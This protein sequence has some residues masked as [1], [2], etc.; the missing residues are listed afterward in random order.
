MLKLP[1]YTASTLNSCVIGVPHR[2]RP[3]FR[4]WPKNV[5][6]ALEY[7]EIT[8]P[9]VLEKSTREYPERAAI[10]F[11]DTTLTYE[12]LYENVKRFASALQDLGVRKGDRVAVYLPNCPQFIVTTYGA[13]E[14]GAVVVPCSTA[15]K[16]MEL[17]RQL[18][19]SGARILITHERLLQI[20]SETVK[21]T[22]IEHLIVTSEQDYRYLEDVNNAPKSEGDKYIPLLKLLQEYEPTPTPV[23]INPRE[24]LAFL[25]YTGGTTGTPKG[26]M[27]THFN[28]VVDQLHE[29]FFYQLKRGEEV[30]LLFLPLF[31]IYGLNRCMGT[32]L[33]AAATI[34]LLERF[35][36]IKV[37]EAIQRYKVTV[38]P[39]VPTVYNALISYS[40]IKKYDL[41]S[42]RIWKSAAAPLPT[43]TWLK[44]RDLVGASIVIGWGLTEAS[45]GLTLTPLE[46]K[47]YKP[48][49]IGIPEIDTDVAVFDPEKDVEVPVGVVGELRARGPQIMKGY[50]N[51][52]EETAKVFSNGWLRTGDLGY[53]DEN[54][55]FY[56][57][58]RLKDVIKVSGFQV[59]PTEVEDVLC[60]HP[61]VLE[62]AVIGVPDEYHGEVPKAYVV[63]RSEHKGRITEEELMKYCEERLAKYKV[64]K[65]IE[66]IEELPKGPSGKILKRKIELKR[67]LAEH[68]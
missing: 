52:P 7:P 45:P 10:I 32:Y 61:A 44:F 48:G 14:A 9:Q 11:E 53:M 30:L 58:G 16:E 67:E 42:V 34:I 41:R 65:K 33:A 4:L 21:K 15:Y 13:L 40:D 22:L 17:K 46:I 23:A 5:P 12:K 36:V 55:M 1:F 24:D 49:M 51:K 18:D 19:D 31:H 25:C 37:L 62:A 68:L 2:E 56:F 59:W 66:F 57:V 60:S 8:L 50:W 6:R 27:L 26:C 43:S 28:C 39:G 47:E 3:W 35:N 29:I 20:A 64:P 54:G 63:L 38:F